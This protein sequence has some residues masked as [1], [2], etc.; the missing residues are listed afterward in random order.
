MPE[1]ACQSVCVNARDFGQLALFIG[2]LL[3]VTPPLGRFMVRVFA[4]E[5]H[6]VSR[7]GGPI[8]RWIYKLAGVDPTHDMSWKAYAV[9]MLVFNVAGTYTYHCTVHPTQMKDYSIEV[10]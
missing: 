3:A 10:K 1:T 6:F 8:E 9:A 4:G 2:G 7:P 5:R